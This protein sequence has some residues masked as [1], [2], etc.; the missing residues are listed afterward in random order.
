MNNEKLIRVA[1][2]VTRYAAAF[3]VVATMLTALSVVPADAQCRGRNRARAARVQPYGAYPGYYNNN[4]GYYNSGYYNPPNNNNYY[5][6]GRA[7][8]ER[9]SKTRD[10]L[11]V[12]GTTAGGAVVGG[13][14]GGK[15]GAILGAA[16]GAGVGGVIVYKKRQRPRYDYPYPY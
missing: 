16:A 7:P 10:A 15:K 5:Y 6:D 2:S 8:W 1:R 3:A 14:L 13:L 4:S 9:R 12:V 11:T